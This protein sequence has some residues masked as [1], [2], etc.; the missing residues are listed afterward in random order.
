MAPQETVGGSLFEER[1][2]ETILVTGAGGF[3][4]G[5]L[6]ALLSNQGVPRERLIA[7]ARSEPPSGLTSVATW[8][9]V[10]LL[11]AADVCTRLASTHPVEVYHC[12][13]SPH[14]AESWHDTATPLSSNVL[15][16]H[17]LLD[18]LRRGGGGSRVLITGSAAVY[19]PS[20]TP[21]AESG[22]LAPSSPYALSKLAQEQLGLRA[23]VEDG[24]DVIVTRPFNHTGPRQTAAFA[25]PSMARQVAL[26]ERGEMEPVIRVGNLDAARDLTDVRDVTQAYV[27]L[28]ASGTT[29]EVYN[30]ASGT[31]R[32]I[33]SI[34]DG[35]VARARVRVR[36]ETDPARMRPNDVPVLAGDPAKLHTATGW[37][38]SISFDRMLDDLLDYWRETVARNGRGGLGASI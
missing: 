38:P 28:M 22:T 8:Q 36:V 34:L 9:R 31:A 13:G 29:G 11:D 19:A 30:V 15:G 4:G 17:H 26:I 20:A 16:T 33:R 10:D 21:I 18:G 12:A 25:A 23:V 6:V 2:T 3:A 7:W 35:L 32:P 37:T 24:L 5:H 14:V 1:V 27:Q